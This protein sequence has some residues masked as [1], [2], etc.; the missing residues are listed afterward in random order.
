MTRHAFY[1]VTCH[2]TER[3]RHKFIPVNGKQS[4]LLSATVFPSLNNE[5][6]TRVNAVSGKCKLL[7]LVAE[8][9]SDCNK[10]LALETPSYKCFLRHYIKH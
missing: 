4:L 3:P 10:A 6:E 1:L 8:K 9:F 5:T 2:V 7:R